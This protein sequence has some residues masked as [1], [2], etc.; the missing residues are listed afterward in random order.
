M[1]KIPFSQLKIRYQ[2]R[3]KNKGFVKK[4]NTGID[5]ETYNGYTRLLTDS[6][7]RYKFISS[8]EDCLNFLS[9]VYFRNKF[10]WFFNL[11]YDWESI[12]KYLPKEILLEIYTT[13]KLE[14]NNFKIYYIPK[15]FISISKYH[16]HYY[17]YDINNFLETSLQIA[18]KNY[19][20]KEKLDIINPKRLNVSEKYWLKHEK[21]IIKY[22]IQDSVLTKEIADYFWNIM[23][24]T[25]KFYPKR[26]FSKG[27]LAEEYFLHKCFIP[28]INELS[29]AVIHLAWNGYNGG[30]FE[31][32]KRGYF[33]DVYIY[34]IKSAYPSI[35]AQLNDYNLGKWEKTEKY[36]KN[37]D[38]SFHQCEVSCYTTTFSPF[39]EKIGMLNIYPNGNFYQILNNYEIDFITKNFPECSIK[40]LEGV[41][42]YITNEQFPYKEEI[43]FLYNWK[44]KEKDDDIR[45]SI[46]ILMNSYYGKKVQCVNGITGKL[47]NPIEGNLITSR[48]RLK[49]LEKGLEKPDK[50]ISF[51]TDSVSSTEK[52]SYPKHSKL[53]DFSFEFYGKGSIIMSDIYSLQ[54]KKDKK[55]KDKFRGFTII[56]EEKQETQLEYT[57]E[58]ILQEMKNQGL[59]KFT[60][61]KERPFHLGECLVHTKKRKLTDINIFKKHTKT[62]N[63]NGDKKRIWERDFKNAN[64]A[65][66][67]NISSLPLLL[68]YY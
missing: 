29:P 36:D 53:G 14:Y 62:I 7:G 47:F 45:Y 5:S 26:P 4:E 42:F 18:S 1:P 12:L 35:I 16:D 31:L 17:F 6:S 66:T 2:R 46:K 39:M 57:I 25:I 60:Y 32:L 15:K 67:N 59:T 27:R 49:L 24:N 56:D 23:Y 50:I 40:I 61:E 22:C 54:S 33:E 19:L 64:D 48:T 13:H 8:F 68:K 63:L 65:L 41:K 38:L 34:D 21:D 30:R 20:K 43:E 52:L 37:A 9:H 44:E 58:Y 51:S 3:F 55:R 11:Q 28:T 10:N